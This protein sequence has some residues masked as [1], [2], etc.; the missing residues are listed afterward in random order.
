MSQ[1]NVNIDCPICGAKEYD[2]IKSFADGVVVGAC[3]DCKSMYTPIRHETPEGLFAQSDQRELMFQYGPILQKKV[4][5]F[6]HKIFH[7]YLNLVKEHAPGKR[8]LDVGCAQGF[9]PAISKEEGFEV[10]GVEPGPGMVQFAREKLNL[11]MFEGTLDKV[12][13]GTR[14]WDIIT[15]TDSLEYFPNP[16]GDLKKLVA[17]NL[18]DKGVVFIKVPNGN[19]FK[20]RHNMK[21]KYK[22]SMGAD[23]A[24]SPTMRVMHYDYQS[25]QKLAEKIG[26]EP[27]KVGHFKPINSP[28]WT[29]Y[30]GI[31]LEIESPWWMNWKQK[32]FRGLLHNMGQAQFALTKR[33]NLSQSVYIVGRKK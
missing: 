29:K 30:T 4:R 27:I 8:H 7:D 28:D 14:K 10:T 13:L 6:R 9:F 31:W 16:V 2:Q 21:T 25:I 5:H 11:E 32:L 23:E 1:A 20:F 22:L 17:E 33:N 15:F 26:I 19:Y 18:E 3:K 24:F 12:D